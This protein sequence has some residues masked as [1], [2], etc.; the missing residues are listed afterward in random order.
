MPES[1]TVK[2]IRNMEQIQGIESIKYHYKV[3][4]QI[5]NTEKNQKCSVDNTKILSDALYKDTNI[6]S[7]EKSVMK[8]AKKKSKPVAKNKKNPKR[9]IINVKKCERN[10]KSEI[11]NIKKC[12][13]SL[14]SETQDNEKCE[15]L[16]ENK[17]YSENYC[18][19]HFEANGFYT[20]NEESHN[21]EVVN[22]SE[23]Q[24]V[25]VEESENILK[26]S[27]ITSYEPIHKDKLYRLPHLNVK[28]EFD[29]QNSIS[30]MGLYDKGC[31]DCIIS[32]KLFKT[33]PIAV[34]QKLV[35]C[36][37]PLDVANGKSNSILIGEIDL[38]IAFSSDP[39][40]L[41]PLKVFHKF[42]V[43]TNMSKDLY[44]GA[45]LICNEA[46]LYSE[47]PNELLLKYPPEY[48]ESKDPQG[49]FG[50]KEIPIHYLNNSETTI[51]SNC[52]V[53]MKPKETITIAC[54]AASEKFQNT[55]VVVEELLS[56]A[57]FC[58][59]FNH[60]QLPNIQ[61]QDT[62]VS[63]NGEIS[64]TIMNTKMS[65]LVIP[66]NSTIAR[67][68]RTSSI[69][70]LELSE[71]ERTQQSDFIFHE[72]KEKEE[73]ECNTVLQNSE[74]QSHDYDLRDFSIDNS[75]ELQKK[76]DFSE[77]EYLKM[78]NLT[79]VPESVKSEI[80][81]IFI[82]Y[83]EAFSH[84]TMDIR[85]CNSYVHHIELAA[86]PQLPRQRPF[87]LKTLDKVKEGIENLIDYK[88]MI[89][90]PERKHYS[91]FVPV[92]KP[93]G[94][95]RLCC[96]LILLNKVIKTT[97]KIARMGSPQQLFYRF[98][99]K[100]MIW[101]L[102]LNNAYFHMPV[103]DFTKQYYGMYSYKTTQDSI[104]FQ[105]VIQGEKS[106]VWSWNALMNKIFGKMP[107]I[108]T[109][110]DD[111]LIFGDTYEELLV[112]L[113][114]VVEIVHENG[115]SIAPAKVNVSKSEITF[116]GFVINKE[117]G[118]KQIPEAKIQG[119]QNLPVPST[120]TGLYSFLMSLNYF[121]EHLPNLAETVQ[122]LREAMREKKQF[123]VL[124]WNSERANAFVNTKHL[125]AN[126]IV[127][128][129]PDLSEGA[130]FKLYCDASY[131]FYGMH[132]VNVSKDGE[133]RTISVYSGEFQTKNLNWSMY[134]KEFYAVI[135]ATNR[136][137]QYLLDYKIK[138]YTDCKALLYISEA[139]IDNSLT[140]RLAMYLSGFDL[141]FYH[142]KGVDNKADFLSRPYTSYLDTNTSKPRKPEEIEQIVNSIKVK[143][144]YSVEEVRSLLTYNFSESTYDENRIEQ[145]KQKAKNLFDSFSLEVPKFK[146]PCCDKCKIEV[147]KSYN[148]S[149]VNREN[150]TCDHFEENHSEEERMPFVT[151]KLEENEEKGQH[152]F[153]RFLNVNHNEIFESDLS[154]NNPSQ[155]LSLI[156]QVPSS[157][158]YFAK[159]INELSFGKE[160]NNIQPKYPDGHVIPSEKE[161]EIPLY[162][163][164][165]NQLVT[166]VDKF[167][168]LVFRDGVL[169]VQNLI[170]A[171][172]DDATI[173]KI[174]NELN[175]KSAAVRSKAE[176]NYELIQEVLFKKN[177]SEFP[178]KPRICIP[179]F[180]VPYILEL[181]HVYP[182]G[183][184]KN[185]E[186]MCKNVS[187]KYYFKNIRD[188]CQKKINNCRLC[189][190]VTKDTRPTQ[191]YGTSR[192]ILIP[193]EHIVMDF[194][195]SLP[196][197]TE[198]YVNILIVMDAY[199]RFS[200]FYP[201]KTRTSQEILSVFMQSF[202]PIFQMPAYI[203]ADNEKSFHEGIFANYMRSFGVIF[204]PL[205]PYRPCSAGKV[206]ANVNRCKTALATFQREF[207]SRKDWPLYLHMVNAG[208]NN[209]VHSSI[210][211][212]PWLALYGWNK[213]SHVLDILRIDLI[214]THDTTEDEKE[215]PDPSSDETYLLKRINRS[216]I[217]KHI[218]RS[219]EDT[220]E[221]NL[222]QLNKN[223]N[224]RD[225]KVGDKV[226]RK[227]HRHTYQQGIN[228]QL[229]GKFTG[230]YTIKE[231]WKYNLYLIDD[232][233]NQEFWESKA[234]CKP[235]RAEEPELK[236]PK[237][238]FKHIDRFGKASHPMTTRSKAKQV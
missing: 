59:E 36:N 102:D 142:C 137:I 86:Q 164:V 163:P 224:Q 214:E 169:S 81:D 139:K 226:K 99:T 210:K 20:D 127:N 141:E 213:T 7:V 42:F 131:Y 46:F 157:V 80:Q 221:K 11:I 205:I 26:E 78:F 235:F 30:V 109:W 126:A 94:K 143:D 233:T 176:N 82:E 61:P 172:C 200:M 96:D 168:S 73:S 193:L 134:M 186:I 203:T 25:K 111:I 208:L 132:L 72:A 183:T 147:H 4:S 47:R 77:S 14:K 45:D 71:I 154:E 166:K 215:T 133:E 40:D 160:I 188:E 209:S 49:S 74:K 44:F 57:L 16:S 97:N 179:K 64:V 43:G 202:F 28:I 68:K 13:K 5:E 234:H 217:D 113:R 67:I 101:S 98:F 194:A 192:Q 227:R 222:K 153:N 136:Y 17:N 155:K 138:V 107:N 159:N 58:E 87:Q 93:N 117:K 95:V 162:A 216:L 24:E 198:G 170:R 15:K 115:L 121:A 187:S 158:T 144:H 54:T 19:S 184:H 151:E 185:I 204:K 41:Y 195:V 22:S 173:N 196:P 223:A 55:S 48:Y 236:V 21:I 135:Y 92:P 29:K 146:S 156:G 212:S 69:P 165:P 88:I 105:R 39:T 152:I 118:C 129:F 207:G 32:E 8:S 229:E 100:K 85:K 1:E 37:H 211:M 116:L 206:E 238:T 3:N 182:M 167:K 66:T 140:Y 10:P 177:E 128:Y 201:M 33:F 218:R 110:I 237:S 181:E 6:F 174:R 23:I 56:N 35:K 18:V 12:E 123:P 122:P 65:N 150:F 52:E 112:T 119:I 76:S 231:V 130:Y 171:Q 79:D 63:E 31:T 38:T 103:S 51:T 90:G 2:L 190:Y 34:Q 84:F 70:T 178:Y 197:S 106:A 145:C 161:S 108:V 53:I 219:D 9:E 175:S 125:V 225:F 91:N 189:A 27:D 104:S 199:T 62:T 180:L 149:K 232:A 148:D 75:G 60:L 114:K 220:I 89:R 83:R 230:P 228:T 124:K 50:C 120:Y 191:P